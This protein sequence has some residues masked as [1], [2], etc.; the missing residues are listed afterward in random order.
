MKT[1]LF[2]LLLSVGVCAQGG[3]VPG[4]VAVVGEAEMRVAPD[5]VY[6]TLEVIT[7]AREV[8]AAKRANDL[9]AG[10]LVTA[11]RAFNIAEEDV[12]TESFTISPKYASVK[13]SGAAREEKVLAGYEVT[14]RTRVTL[15]DLKRVDEFL[16]RAIDAGVNRVVSIDIGHSEYDKFA[17]QT[18]AMAVKNA[19][20]KARAYAQQLG[21]TLGKAYIIREEEADRPGWESGYG[22]GNGNGDGDGDTS[23]GSAPPVAFDRAVTFALGRIELAEKIYVTFELKR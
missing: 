10:K 14:N 20:A 7:S 5:E 9:A 4:S 3:G 13:S 16:T 18:R 19:E 1:M 12:R 22:S 23:F 6:F 8:A 17:A 15:K 11:T 21:L 2:L